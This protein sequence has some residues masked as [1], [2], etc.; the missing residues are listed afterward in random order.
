M[1]TICDFMR[2]L[3]L[4]TAVT[5]ASLQ[6]LPVSRVRTH[7]R[8]TAYGTCYESNSLLHADTHVVTQ[9][10]FHRE[11]CIFAI[12]GCSHFACS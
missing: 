11:A 6:V 1:A 4:L 12:W 9:P 3:M 10:C 5:P 8:A 2:L 7:L